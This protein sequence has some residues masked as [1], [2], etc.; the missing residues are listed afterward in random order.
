MK[1]PA[2]RRP[3]RMYCYM[4]KTTEYIQITTE[5]ISG[6]AGEQ[7]RCLCGLT[8]DS[9]SLRDRQFAK[10]MGNGRRYLRRNFEHELQFLRFSTA[11]GY[12]LRLFPK[13]LMP[14]LDCIFPRRQ[15]G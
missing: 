10:T 12:H 4:E 2:K 11:D 3:T 6:P 8:I 5:D 9:K 1:M 15:I 13:L 7:F 14:C